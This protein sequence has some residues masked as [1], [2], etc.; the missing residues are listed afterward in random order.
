MKPIPRIKPVARY[1]PLADRL[2]LVRTK[3]GETQRQFAFHFNVNAHTIWMWE[4]YG[5]PRNAA[6]RIGI[7]YI[8]R[9]LSNNR[10][11]WRAYKERKLAKKKAAAKDAGLTGA[12][13]G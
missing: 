11:D 6:A 8:L 13:D 10:V 5:P 2:R 9:K 7:K 4:K 12:V 1:D 3:L